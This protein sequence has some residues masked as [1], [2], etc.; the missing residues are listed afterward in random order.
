MPTLRDM[1]AQKRR[2]DAR[3]AASTARRAQMGRP[4]T[5]PMTGRPL[6]RVDGAPSAMEEAQKSFAANDPGW[7]AA[8]GEPE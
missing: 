8:P 4:A 1:D 5:N 6:I 7:R 2:E 3:R